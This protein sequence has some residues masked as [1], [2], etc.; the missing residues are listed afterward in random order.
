MVIQVNPFKES[1]VEGDNQTLP[2]IGTFHGKDEIEKAG[3]I[4]WGYVNRS[5]QYLVKLYVHEDQAIGI[6]REEGVITK[7][8]RAFKA[9]VVT[10]L[11]LDTSKG[12]IIRWMSIYPASQVLPALKSAA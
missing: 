3:M 9:D 10:W 12:K 4:F 11:Q 2:W 7:T 8:G 6:V 1:Y 5:N